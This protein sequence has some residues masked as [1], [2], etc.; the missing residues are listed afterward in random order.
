VSAPT[1]NTTLTPERP[2]R[3]RPTRG[4][5]R[6]RDVVENDNYAA[7]SRRIVAAHG[8]R[9]ATGDI[10]GL[11]D[12]AHLSTLVDDAMTTAV[13]GLRAAGYSWAEI[14]DRL[15]VTRQAAHQRFNPGNGS[16]R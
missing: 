3:A 2:E 11:A 15:G 16:V 12:L 9:I 14:A 8:R 6:R 10:E 1:V 4:T 5:R 7:F 13:T